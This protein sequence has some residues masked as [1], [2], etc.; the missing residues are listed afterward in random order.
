MSCTQ[1]CVA[2][3]GVLRST[4]SFLICSSGTFCLQYML[5]SV[6]GELHGKS[7]LCSPVALHAAQGQVAVA[8]DLAKYHGRSGGIGS[9]LS[10]QLAQ[11][12]GAQVVLAGRSQAKLDKLKSNIGSGQVMTVDVGNG[13]EVSGMLQQGLHHTGSP[14]TSQ[15]EAIMLQVEELLMAVQQ[16]H[17]HI[18]GVTNLVGSVLIKPLLITTQEEVHCHRA[19]PT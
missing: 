16:E 10:H 3:E 7:V 8:A 9:N 18:S 4:Q 2:C 19:L 11:Q 13:K 14:H 15:P 5:S 6:P 12:D 17:G 1:L